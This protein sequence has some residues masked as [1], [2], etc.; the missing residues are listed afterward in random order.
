MMAAQS[1][2][3]QITLAELLQGMAGQIRVPDMQVTGLASDSRS[4]RQGDLFLAAAGLQVHGIEHLSQ[5]IERGAAAV[6]WEP[7]AD[8]SVKAQIEACA[9][10]CVAVDHLQR[11]IGSIA[12]RFYA[13]P[14][15]HMFGIGVTGTDG[16]TSVTHFI[17]Q[18]LSAA[19]ES[20][21]LLGTLGYGIY[22]S[23]QPPTHTTPDAIRLQ[24]EL[25]RLLDQGVERFTME[26]SSHALHQH[27]TDGVAFDVAVLTQLSRDHLDYH[28]SIE[29]Y[30]EAKR[31]LFLAPGLSTAVL[32]TGDEFGRQ[33]AAQ[34]DNELRVIAWSRGPDARK[35]ASWIEAVDVQ[36]LSRGLS[37]KLDSSWGSAQLDCSLLGTFNA[38]NLCAALGA[39]LASGLEFE[40]AVQRLSRVHTV[41]GRMQ[42]LALPGAPRVIVDYAHTAN[43]LET[44]LKAL[45]PHCK[46]ELV[47]V[48]GAGGDRDQGKRPLMGRVA[49]QYADRII[50]TSDNPRSEHPQHIIEQVLAG[51]DQPERALRIEDRSSALQTAILDSCSD[52]LVLVA[53]KG[54]EDTQQVG[55][56]KFP[57]SDRLVIQQLLRRYVS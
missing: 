37:L 50:I 6:V 5:A 56:E 26:V 33:L 7:C 27:R 24:Y 55:A 17:A 29:A 54:H 57:F 34:L 53:G 30:A 21:G 36:P 10:P 16:K 48:F 20:C 38:D 15:K 35:Y 46:G 41:P 3:P 12:E 43:A 25:A 14:S 45:R 42:L 2:P 40:D 51:F 11:Q 32:N 31:R 49:E 18:A 8:A 39:L 52:D 4:V 1:V 23:L 19:N 22:A 44:A 9:L 47:C 28:G 13:S